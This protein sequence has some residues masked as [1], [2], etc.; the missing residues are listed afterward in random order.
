MISHCAN[1]DCAQELRYLRGGKVYLF[2]V[3]AKAGGKKTEYYWLCGECSRSMV[4][5]CVNQS[6]V[7]TVRALGSR[8]SIHE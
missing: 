4:L 6:E 7:K 1:P 8:A 2:D 5:T 3:P